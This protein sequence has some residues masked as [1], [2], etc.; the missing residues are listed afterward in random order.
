MGID[1]VVAAHMDY[2]SSWKLAADSCKDY[3][4]KLE[5]GERNN[6]AF[7]PD[8]IVVAVAD[9]YNFGIDYQKSIRTK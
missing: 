7:E 9:I 1:F 4:C 3:L 8:C 5:V 2:C 6:F